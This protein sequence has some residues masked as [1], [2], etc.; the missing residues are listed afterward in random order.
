[1]ILVLV[2][3]ALA[4]LPAAIGTGLVLLALAWS[5]LK[6]IVGLFCIGLLFHMI[7]WAVTWKI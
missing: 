7:W 5:L 3:V 1:M 6:N 4:L 2:I